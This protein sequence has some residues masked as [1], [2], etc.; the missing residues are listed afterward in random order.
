MVSAIS[1]ITHVLLVM[2][3]V[4]MPVWLL[5]FLITALRMKRKRETP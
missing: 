5:W 3:Y 4:A 2:V 1:V